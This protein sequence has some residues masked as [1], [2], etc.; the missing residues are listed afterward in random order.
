MRT[1]RLLALVGG[2]LL[3]TGV[4]QPQQ[5]AIPWQ[6]ANLCP[7]EL[8]DPSVPEETVSSIDV[9]GVRVQL[10]A[11]PLAELAERFAA[12]LGHAGDASASRSWVCLQGED[13]LGRWALWLETGELH[14]GRAG[15]LLLCRLLDGERPDERCRRV[16][17]QAVVGP[18]GLQL[19]LTHAVVVAALGP[20]TAQVAD[21]LVWIHSHQES[22][23]SKGD[24]RPQ[25]FDV[26]STL[27][28]RFRDS[29]V[30]AFE[31]WRVTSR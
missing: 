11:A 8:P 30:D 4:A 9:G 28:V 15:A 18:V 2:S 13:A 22:V 19:G 25:L 20:P 10:E 5:L 21:T 3:L 24:A 29:R 14:G 27:C 23:V 26:G 16:P 6:P 1:H 17:G 31:V 12:A 7:E